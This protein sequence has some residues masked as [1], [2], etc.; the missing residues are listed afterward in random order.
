[1]DI[2]SHKIHNVLRVFTRR[3]TRFKQEAPE[4]SISEFRNDLAEE[5]RTAVINQ[6][7]GRIISETMKM[8]SRPGEIRERTATWRTAASSRIGSR[9]TGFRYTVL[10]G[11]EQRTETL[12]W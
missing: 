6:I 5:K 12:V 7:S 3:L 4:K 10:L 2:P 1:M 9:H 11:D 8:A